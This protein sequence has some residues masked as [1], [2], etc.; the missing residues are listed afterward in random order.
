[1][2]INQWGVCPH[3]VSGN[4]WL[5]IVDMLNSWTKLSYGL[6]AWLL[7][8]SGDV[9][10]AQTGTALPT[11][12]GNLTFPADS[13]TPVG[14]GTVGPEDSFPQGV[15]RVPA[16]QPAGTA[17]AEDIV[18]IPV[19]AGP[20]SDEPGEVSVRSDQQ[21]VSIYARDVDVNLV[22][23]QL[24]EEAD[25][26]IV[27]GPGVE[28]TVNIN[29]RRV[30][31]AQA[32]DA[33]LKI[34]GLAWTEQDSIVYVTK[35]TPVGTEAAGGQLL[36]RGLRGQRLEVFDLNFVQAAEVLAV[37]KTLLSPSGTANVHTADISNTRQTRERIVVEDYDDRL[38]VIREYLDR[39]DN[40]PRQ[41]LIEAHV[42]QVTLDNDQRH[43]VNLLGLAR[44]AGARVEMRAQ[45]FAD[46]SASPGFMMGVDGT[47]LDGMIEMLQ[48]SSY[49]R[50]L[51]APKVMV[52]NGQEARIQ[53]GSKFGYFETTTT[54]TGTFQNVNF[55][56]IG[57]VLQVVPTITDDG[58]V[59]LAVQPKVSGGRVNPNTGLPEE[60]TTEATTTVLLPDGKGMIIGGLIKEEDDNRRSWIPW[61]GK[62]PVIG[63]LFSR[64]Q[65]DRQRA[66]VIIALTPHIVPYSA[67]IAQRESQAYVQT[68]DSWGIISGGAP[69]TAAENVPDYSISGQHSQLPAPH[70]QSSIIG[71][72]DPIFGPGLIESPRGVPNR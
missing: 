25:V 35:P 46:G 41:V 50:T 11:V 30:S 70:G 42:L 47:D 9:V 18:S 10:V 39:V 32:L 64:T 24:A 67:C 51:A 44:I 40:A 20:G 23:A 31:L 48:S 2:S 3:E 59:M 5:V 63:K 56:D 33:V 54:Q 52:V 17:Q 21:S 58:H 45:G 27:I 61:I 55:L 14:P 36:G 22:L 57:V 72:S 65:Q 12:P 1:M 71:D 37:V 13:R 34:N 43:G 7:C 69:H 60:D 62:Q 38:A 26:N 15:P 68:T 4:R 6:L 8:S 19:D 28:A 49:V 29:L 53:I 66:E 16:F